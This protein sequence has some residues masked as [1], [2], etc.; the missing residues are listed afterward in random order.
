MEKRIK[1]I[2]VLLFIASCCPSP[3]TI[4]IPVPPDP[5]LTEPPPPNPFI[6][7]LKPENEQAHRCLSKKGQADLLE[8]LVLLRNY[9]EESWK[10]FGPIP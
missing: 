4:Y 10:L 2:I 8:Y 3:K 7:L 5:S 9:A 6:D 1:Y